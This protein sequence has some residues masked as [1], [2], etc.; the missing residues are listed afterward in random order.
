MKKSSLLLG[1][2]AVSALAACGKSGIKVNPDKEEYV[3]GI[4]QYAPHPALDAATEGFKEKLTALLTAEGRKVTYEFNNCDGKDNLVQTNITNLVA[5]DVDLIMANATPCVS[6]AYSSTSYIPILGTSVTEYGVACDIEI[7]DGMTK[8]N[9]SGT[10]D[11]APLDQQAENMV[12][13]LPSATKIGLLYSASE[14]NSK[15]Q[16]T[17]MKKYLTEKGKTVTEYEI[18]NANVLESVC[19][20]AAAAEDAIYIP[21]DNFCAS[22]GSAIEP[23]FTANNIPV[24]AGESGICKTCGFATLSIDYFELGKITGEMAFNVL[25]GKQDIREYAIQYYPTPKKQYVKSRCE[26]LGITV[27]TDYEELEIEAE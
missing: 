11:L 23:I 8:T 6:Q 21:T 26:A 24:Y 3:V 13:L 22:N 2:V 17:E 7:V 27:P 10:S 1:V 9:V 25:L 5:K 14:A 12:Q 20:T 16:V 15:F 4:A 19:N 18:A